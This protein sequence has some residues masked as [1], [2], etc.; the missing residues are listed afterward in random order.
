MPKNGRIWRFLVQVYDLKSSFLTF[1][2]EFLVKIEFLGFWGNRV[3]AKTHKKKPVVAHK[4]VSIFQP[5]LILDS[6]MKIQTINQLKNTDIELY[7][8]SFIF[9]VHHIMSEENNSK[10]RTYLLIDELKDTKK[11]LCI[12]NMG[13]YKSQVYKFTYIY[14]NYTLFWLPENSK[15]PMIFI[16]LVI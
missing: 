4:F 5:D 3:F 10:H 7:K 11:F 16:L 15:C 2:I 1:E 12:D 14:K 6:Y 9:L 8:Q 13:I